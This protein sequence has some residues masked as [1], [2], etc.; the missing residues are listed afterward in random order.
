LKGKSV[1]NVRLEQFDVFHRGLDAC[2]L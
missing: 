2:G 1:F